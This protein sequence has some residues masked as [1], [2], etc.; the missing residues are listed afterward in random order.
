MEF[1]EEELRI[2]T[3]RNRFFRRPNKIEE[4][5]NLRRQRKK[6]IDNTEKLKEEMVEWEFKSVKILQDL[7]YA[8]NNDIVEVAKIELNLKR[9]RLKKVN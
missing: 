5:I 4:E 3:L 6:K 1:L 7:N 8:M 9:L 2:R